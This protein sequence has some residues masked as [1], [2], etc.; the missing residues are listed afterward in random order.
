M[1]LSLGNQ[2]WE[3]CSPA[4]FSFLA[5]RPLRIRGRSC[6]QQ[7]PP[8]RA[9]LQEETLG[10]F[11]GYNCQGMIP[12]PFFSAIVLS[13]NRI[14]SPWVS[15][16]FLERFGSLERMEMKGASRRT[17]DARGGIHCD[18]S[19]LGGAIQHGQCLRRSQRMGTD[20]WST[21]PEVDEWDVKCTRGNSGSRPLSHPFASEYVL[22][23]LAGFQGDLSP[24]DLSQKWSTS[25]C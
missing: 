15:R 16:V 21:L 20:Y 19:C 23:C 6:P 24:L 8:E 14:R 12:C 4:F 9:M 17:P 22:F 11:F 25:I 3:P 2:G 13:K 7:Q 18:R 1:T 5:N 10:G